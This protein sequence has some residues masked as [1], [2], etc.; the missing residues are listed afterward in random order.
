MPGIGAIVLAAGASQRYG[1]NNKLLASIGG[2]PLVRRVVH[3]LIESGIA[4]IVVVTGHERTLIQAALDGAPHWL[5]AQRELGTRDGVVD[6]RRR[7]RPSRRR[8][9]RVHRARRH[10]VP[11][12]G[13]DRAPH[14][15][16]RR[17]RPNLDRLSGDERWGAAQSGALAAALLRRPRGAL[18]D[19]RVQSSFLPRLVRNASPS[20]STT[21]PSPT[22][23]PRPTWWPPARG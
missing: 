19:P 2:E 15:R 3:V 11:Y 22:L 23:T 1:A 9:R 13:Y 6:C 17:A 4:D 18:G 10:A 16:F 12:G 8:R 7:V 14:R 21:M 5:C 20:P